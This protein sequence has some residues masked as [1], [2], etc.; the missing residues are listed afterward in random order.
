MLGRDVLAV[1]VDLTIV[2][3]WFGDVRPRVREK[4]KRTRS[5]VVDVDV[6]AV[7]ETD[8]IK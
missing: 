6:R 4:E 2:C 1:P 8:S 3:V 7:V 5:R